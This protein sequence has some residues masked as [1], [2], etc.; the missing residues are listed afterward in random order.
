MTHYFQFYRPTSNITTTTP[1][2]SIQIPETIQEPNAS[3]DSNTELIIDETVED[4][5]LVIDEKVDDDSE[6]II[7]DHVDEHMDERLGEHELIIDEHIDESEEKID[8]NM[9]S[10]PTQ[11]TKAT[12]VETYMETTVHDRKMPQVIIPKNLIHPSTTRQ[13]QPI[14]IKYSRKNLETN[15]NTTIALPRTEIFK[16]ETPEVDSLKTEMG[17]FHVKE[18]E[19]INLEPTENSTT[20]HLELVQPIVIQCSM[21]NLETNENTTIAIPRT[22]II[23]A[24]TPE[25]DPLKTEMGEFHVKEDEQ[26]TLEPTENC[27]TDEG[28]HTGI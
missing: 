24:E 28:Y 1:N 3:Y 4:P 11:E 14:V 22:E 10:M 8:E 12:L 19:Q 25:V 26:T 6:L 5:E 7:D 16:V 21:K 2:N 18:T 9:D 20:K 17:E 23:K 13:L 15:E 27:E